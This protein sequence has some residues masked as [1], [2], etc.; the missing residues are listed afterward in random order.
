V[1]AALFLPPAVTPLAGR[2]V[3]DG[4]SLPEGF[5][6][7]AGEMFPDQAI[8]ALTATL[9]SALLLDAWTNAATGGETIGQM[10]ADVATDVDAHFRSGATV[11]LTRGGAGNVA[12]LY[13]GTNDLF[14]ATP[15]DLL[16]WRWL[17][18][19]RGRRA[20]GWRTIACTLADDQY[21][22]NPGSFAADR[23]WFN[24]L[25]E[26]NADEYDVLLDVAAIPEA[27]DA[28]NGTYFQADK[29][30]WKAPLH[31]IV[32]AAAAVAI[33]EAIG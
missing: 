17:Q 10:I 25:V 31:A 3:F 13:G 11:Q 24:A 14:Y 19:M 30:H 9:G 6:V 16:E 21:A 26:A 23:L 7:S 18:W 8:D 27:Q 12:L 28:T 33:N 4:D 15:R 1:R 5:G 2:I 29:V 32:G 20:A 22:T